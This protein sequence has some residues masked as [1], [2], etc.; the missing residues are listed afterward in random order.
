[1]NTTT[2]LNVFDTVYVCPYCG[3]EYGEP[4]DTCCHENHLEK[5]RAYPEDSQDD[6]DSKLNG[7]SR[8]ISD[9]DYKDYLKQTDRALITSMRAEQREIREELAFRASW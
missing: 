1:M 4:Y 3:S 8:A 9:L 6:L 7:L 5:R 2:S